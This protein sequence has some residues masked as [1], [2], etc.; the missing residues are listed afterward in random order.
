MTS[1]DTEGESRNY[2]EGKVV[3][4]LNNRE[5]VIDVG[6]EDGV[7]VGMRFAILGE[8][9]I[10]SSRAKDGK[11]KVPY[12][13]TEVKIVRFVDEYHSV[14]RTFKKIPGQRGN[15]WATL[16]MVASE[17]TPDRVETVPIEKGAD[18]LSR[19]PAGSNLVHIGDRAEE[20]WGDEFGD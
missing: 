5:V 17:G 8:A 9:E 16:A 3:A 6:E 7:E 2:V 11:L 10:E 19:L 14:G 13:K 20:T 1:N 18:L 4:I 15:S 12:R